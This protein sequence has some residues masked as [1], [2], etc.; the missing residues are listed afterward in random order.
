MSSKELLLTT[1]Q[2]T[3]FEDEIEKVKCKLCI[4]VFGCVVIDKY[5]EE[6]DGIISSWGINCDELE[7][8]YFI[9][10]GK[11]H[12]EFESNKHIISLESKGVIDDYTSASFKQYL[13]IQWIL[14]K[15]E[16][17]FLYITGSDIYVNVE[18]MLKVIN[19]YDPNVSLFI[20]NGLYMCRIFE[21]DFQIHCGGA[22]FILSRNT[23]NTIKPHLYKFQE[24]WLSIVTQFPHYN[25]YIPAC[26]VSMSLLCYLK[27]IYLTF[28]PRMF[29]YKDPAHFNN[30]VCIHQIKK[31]DML[32]IFKK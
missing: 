24:R 30:F 6:V 5:K 28:E 4:L 10:V 1:E 18:E 16:P 21:Y 3:E 17:E 27:E 13:G 22:G 19:N 14:S 25:M 11:N 20:G 26:D 32:N 9:F 8:P 7:V 2:G 15:Y 12:E 31:E 23:I 29:E